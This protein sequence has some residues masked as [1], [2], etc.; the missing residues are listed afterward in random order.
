MS[1]QGLEALLVAALTLLAT[2]CL[3]ALLAA[4]LSSLASPH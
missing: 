3:C 4:V 1:R 2:G